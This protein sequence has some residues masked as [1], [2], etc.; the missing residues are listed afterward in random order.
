MNAKWHHVMALILDEQCGTEPSHVFINHL[1]FLFGELPAPI[2]CSFL[3]RFI[4]TLAFFPLL[5]YI[6]FM[7]FYLVCTKNI[8][9]LI[10][11]DLNFMDN[12]AKLTPLWCCLFISMNFAYIVIIHNLFRALQYFYFT[13]FHLPH[14]SEIHS[15]VLYSFVAITV[16]FLLLFQIPL[17]FYSCLITLVRTSSTML[18]HSSE[19]ENLFSWYQSFRQS[20]RLLILVVGFYKCCL[21]GS[22]YLLFLLCWEFL[23]M[24]GYWILSNVFSV[25]IETFCNPFP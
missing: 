11:V 19:S 3:I 14:F 23:S 9:I 5:F 8:E 12:L 15:W 1:C 2:L 21:S 4:F 25:F 22:I 6:S 24:K 7:I 18:G 10:K 20:I 13:F 16:F 17:I